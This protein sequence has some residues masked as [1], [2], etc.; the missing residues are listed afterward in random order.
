MNALITHKGHERRQDVNQSNELVA[1]I[2]VILLALGLA[3]CAHN[4]APPTTAQGAAFDYGTACSGS[5]LMSEDTF[6]ETS[7]NTTFW[8]PFMSDAAVGDRWNNGGLLP[9]PYSST[10]N[11]PGGNVISYG[12]PYNYGFATPIDTIHMAGGSGV[13]SLTAARG[14]HFSSQGY[15]WAGAVFSSHAK[16]PMV[17]PTTGCFIQVRAKSPDR[18]YGAWPAIWMLPDGSGSGGDEFDISDGAIDTTT[19]TANTHS[20]SH[21]FGCNVHQTDWATPGGVDVTTGYH[22][23]G[24]EYLPSVS[25]KVWFDGTL[26]AND[27]LS[28]CTVNANFELILSMGI[29][30]PSTSGFYPQPDGVHNGPFEWDIND[31]QIYNHP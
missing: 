1:V 4:M 9:S 27:S 10:A 6:T 23:Y 2:R 18:R 3:G 8:N 28:G 7:L 21:W 14:N 16:T 25:F 20:A 12:D 26:V 11:S 30:S 31:V 29:A 5:C 13:L 17:C 15:T 24:M 19:S 22:V